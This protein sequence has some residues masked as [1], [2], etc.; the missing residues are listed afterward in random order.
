M[1]VHDDA[2]TVLGL[3]DLASM[4]TSPLLGAGKLDTYDFAPTG[5]HLIG[6]TNVSVRPN[7][8]IAE[9]TGARGAADERRASMDAKQLTS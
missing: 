4:T 2:R 8:P 9:R 3:V 6:T 1:V 7:A 5:S